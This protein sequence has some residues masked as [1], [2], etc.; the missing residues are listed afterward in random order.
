[1]ARFASYAIY[2]RQSRACSGSVLSSCDAQFSIY[3]DFIQAQT[4]PGWFWIGERLD[5]LGQSGAHTDRPALQRL[6]HPVRER[7]RTRPLLAVHICKRCLMVGFA[8]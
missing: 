5:D 8:D 4:T 3:R 7:N 1:M 2:T 6:M